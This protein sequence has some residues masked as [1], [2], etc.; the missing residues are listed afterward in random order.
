MATATEPNPSGTTKVTAGVSPRPLSCLAET[1]QRFS[2]N[3][4][5]FEC[6]LRQTADAGFG[7]VFGDPGESLRETRNDLGI[8]LEQRQRCHS[9]LLGRIGLRRAD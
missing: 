4:L 5:L 9:H 1:A 7:I 3:F 2:R 6:V 8:L